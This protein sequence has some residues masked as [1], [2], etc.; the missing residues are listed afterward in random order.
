VTQPYVYRLE[1]K[2][3]GK[4][5]IGCRFAKKCSPKDLGVTYFTSSKIVA[6]LFK[7][8]PQRFNCFIV[9][10]GDQNYVI[11]VEKTMLDFNNAVISDKYYNRTSGR[12]IHPDD[13]LAGAYKE[14]AKRS[15]ELYARIVHNMRSKTTCEHYVKGAKNAYEKMTPD[16]RIAK[17][18][19][20]R[21]N[22]TEDSIARV[23]LASIQRAKE[24]PQ[25]M[26]EMGRI[27]GKVGGPIGCKKTNVQLWRCLECGMLSKPGPIGKHQSRSGHVGKERVE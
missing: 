4:F 5:Y 16:E 20:M 12:A 9:V 10:T 6:P 18:A 24:N 23:T 1:D 26:S 14:H 21:G 17:M 25:R 2:E 11:N 22:I 15:P 19:M 8:N 3:T 27:G 7:E 13:R